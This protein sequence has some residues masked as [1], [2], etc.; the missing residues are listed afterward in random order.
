MKKILPLVVILHSFYCYGQQKLDSAASIVASANPYATM[1]GEKMYEKG[2]N[3]YDA[4]TAAA[5]AL[6]VVE[7]SM[8][9][10]GGRLQ[11]I[12]RNAKGKIK[13]ID[14]T[15]QVPVQFVA[16]NANE[17]DGFTTIGVP[18]VVKGLIELQQ[19]GG[20]LPLEVVM[21]PAIEYAK[22]GFTLL[23]DEADRIRSVKKELQLFTSTKQHFFIGDTL[24]RGGDLFKQPALAQT[25]KEIAADQGKSF[26][27][28]ATAAALSKEIKD[29]GGSLNW[30]DLANYKTQNSTIHKGRY[31][32]YEIYSIG[33]PSYGAIVIEMLQL[34]EQVDLK[35]CSEADY[36]LY[37]AKAHELA[38]EDRKLLKTNEVLLIK[39]EFAAKR[40]KE[41]ATAVT[42]S[43]TIALVDTK[44]GHTTHLVAADNFG[45]IISL[46]QSLGPTM[47]SKVASQNGGFMLATTMGPY[48]GKMAPGERASSHISPVILYKEG[49]PVL[50]LGAAGGA[51]IVPAVVQTISRFIDRNLPLDKA[52]AAARV[53]QLSDKLLVENHPGV[54][55]E[56][57]QTLNSIKN[58]KSNL[59]IVTKAA[60]FGRVQAVNLSPSGKWVGAADPDWSGTVMGKN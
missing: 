45:N 29:G 7:P 28:G 55:W 31:R 20:M 10:L 53:F 60:Q 26:Y 17:E 1:A 46:T 57:N 27:Q 22:D 15:T 48:L 44:N 56:D 24:P 25:L 4:I 11:A 12:H 39:P 13:G 37:H 58:K 43:T 47:G 34:L 5:F 49:K 23:A 33:M 18:G 59:E 36:L 41:N 38:Y 16:A 54:F 9:G 6:S 51:R 8:S 21:T 42:D 52:I 30:S 19:S 3:A 50:A 35:N 40:W 14:A 32:D 2:G